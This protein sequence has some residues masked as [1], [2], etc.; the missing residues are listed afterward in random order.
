MKDIKSFLIGFLL[1][2]VLFLSLGF[3]EVPLGS[4]SWKPMYVKIVK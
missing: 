3:T 2:V 4:T 1:A